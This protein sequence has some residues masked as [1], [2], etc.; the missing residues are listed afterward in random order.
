MSKTPTLKGTLELAKLMAKLREETP[1]PYTVPR[2]TEAKRIAFESRLLYIDLKNYNNR[3]LMELLKKSQSTNSTRM[4]D[5]I[6]AEQ[7][8]R[9]IEEAKLDAIIEELGMNNEI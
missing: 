7:A 8:Y 4:A 9:K 6:K 5:L 2:D 3:V 1:Y